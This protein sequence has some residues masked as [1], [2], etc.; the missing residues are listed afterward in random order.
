MYNVL[1]QF[2][3]ELEVVAEETVQYDDTPHIDK[4]REFDDGTDKPKTKFVVPSQLAAGAR[5]RRR[6]RRRSSSSNG[7]SSNGASSNGA[8]SRHSGSSSSRSNTPEMVMV[9]GKPGVAGK[10]ESTAGSRSRSKGSRSSS[11][12]SSGGTEMV[13]V[14]LGGLLAL[15]IAYMLLFWVFTKDPLNL[16][17][18]IHRAFPFAVPEVLIPDSE[19]ES[20]ETAVDELGD[21][22]GDDESADRLPI[23]ELDP[24][25][26][27]GDSSELGY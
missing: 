15:P 22:L 26:I 7:S 5:K 16:A 23:P 10:P 6:G 14:V 27:H 24:D 2:V 25:D 4:I 1:D 9:G 8:S 3:P 19:T 21:E 11:K 18:A 20:V 13:K 17:P 12:G